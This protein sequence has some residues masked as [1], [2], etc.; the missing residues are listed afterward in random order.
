MIM[1]SRVYKTLP[2]W[3]G[4]EGLVAP[5]FWDLGHGSLGCRCAWWMMSMA[6]GGGTPH[7]VVGMR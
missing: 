1:G 5:W 7:T 4:G 3:T 2:R 6:G